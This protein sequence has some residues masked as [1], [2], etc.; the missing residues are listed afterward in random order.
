MTRKSL[1]ERIK[2]QIYGGFESDDAQIT[3]NLINQWINDGIGVAVKKNYT[4][5][6]Q[7]DGC[8]YV[9]NSFYTTFKG[10]PVTKDEEYIYKVLLPQVPIAV[11]KNEGIATL[12]F[13]KGINLSYSAIPLSINQIGY[14]ATMRKIPNKIVFWPQGIYAF[15]DSL[16]DLTQY[17]ATVRLIS[18]GDNNDLN[19]ILNVPDD[20][21]PLIIDYVSKMLILQKN[22]PQDTINDGVDNK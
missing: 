17:T 18:G 21:I 12:Q 22:M 20:Y 16:I 19:S 10:I 7:L 15:V 1:I 2:R 13:K 4:D 11:G 6:I 9:N 8:S 3:D 14:R 5:S